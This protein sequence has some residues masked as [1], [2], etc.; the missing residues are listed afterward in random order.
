M[1]KLGLI[2]ATALLLTTALGCQNSAR[3]AQSAYWPEITVV[4]VDG[5]KFETTK[6]MTE[7][8]L[9]VSLWSTW[10]V[11]CRRELP[12]LQMFAKENP[13]FSV[14]AVNLGDKPAGVREFADELALDIPILIDSQGRISSA[15][16][17][18]TVPATVLIIDSKVVAIHL[19][20]ISANELNEFVAQNS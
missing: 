17:V 2:F 5:Q 12:Q 10:C 6:L 7:N 1:K 19:G 11:P 13:E 8:V 14:V 15:L 4:D 18:S 9:I 16:Q 3:Q 20:E